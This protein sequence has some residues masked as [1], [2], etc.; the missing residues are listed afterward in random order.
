[1]RGVG[2]LEAYF[3]TCLAKASLLPEGCRSFLVVLAEVV[4]GGKGSAE[5]YLGGRLVRRD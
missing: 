1:M 3:I 5:G 4:G 2:L